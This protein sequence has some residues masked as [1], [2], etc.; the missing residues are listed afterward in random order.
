LRTVLS[1][2]LGNIE[3]D[4]G[5][6]EQV[7]MNLVINARDAMPRGGS[8][9]IET[10]N[11]YLE[12]DYISQHIEISPGAFVRM[13]VTDTGDGMDELT[14]RRVFEPFFTTKEI[15]KGT[16]LGLSTVYGIVKQ[17]GGDIMVYSEIGHGTTFKV[18]LPSVDQSVEQPQWVADRDHQYAGTETILLVE[19]DDVVRRLVC[20]VL[21]SNGYRILE[22][23]SGKAALSI[24]RSHAGV[25]HLLLT[26]VI[27]PAMG[28]RELK[29]KVTNLCP[30]VKILF[31][32][33]YTDDS[34]ANRGIYDA[35][36]A[37]IEKPFTP[38]GLA[39]RV[40]EVLEY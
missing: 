25:I 29:D 14:R 34:V 32:S 24:C 10:Q 15:G 7:I 23:K 22:A 8:L 11:V 39:R 6:I 27:M 18:Y 26:D 9:T 19:D 30:D 38:D 33:G 31:M 3:A 21:T 36:F 40:R 28:G 2:D 5:Q 35:D 1:T 37:F 20:E 4:P 16:G 13:T 17:S 12:D